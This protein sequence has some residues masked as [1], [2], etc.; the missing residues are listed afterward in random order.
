MPLLPPPGKRW[1]LWSVK[2]RH[3]FFGA[4]HSGW[5]C[6]R[7]V[8]LVV[9]DRYWPALRLPPWSEGRHWADAWVPCESEKSFRGSANPLKMASKGS[10]GPSKTGP[11]GSAGP[12]KTAPKG[13]AGPY[14]TVPSRMTC[15]HPGACWLGWGWRG[16]WRTSR[17][18]YAPGLYRPGAPLLPARHRL[19][20]SF[21]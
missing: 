18:L 7:C 8:F 9:P 12:S 3:V 16:S 11:K 17:G 20:P 15:H 5:F 6:P 1:N 2:H 4:V 21:R 10:A 19:H 14:K 13:S